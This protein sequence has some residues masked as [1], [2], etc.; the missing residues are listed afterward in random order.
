M[1]ARTFGTRHETMAMFGVIHLF[2]GK[3]TQA[4]PENH[5]P[6]R[7]PVLNTKKMKLLPQMLYPDEITTLAFYS[8]TFFLIIVGSEPIIVTSYFIGIK[9]SRFPIRVSR[10]L[11]TTV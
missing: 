5:R 9:I 10:D 6:I 1:R 4:H 8:F 7:W 3:P 11:P 2:L